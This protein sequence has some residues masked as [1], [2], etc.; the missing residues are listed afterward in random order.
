MTIMMFFD[1]FATQQTHSKI[2][3]R[4]LEIRLSIEGCR[5]G[6][7]VKGAGR[8]VGS[9]VRWHALDAVLSL[10]GWQFSPQLIGHD[11][12]LQLFHQI[13]IN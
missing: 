9:L 8:S 1:V 3:Y 10:V 7:V 12:W 13:R 2:F 4:V 5:K 6:H 11:E